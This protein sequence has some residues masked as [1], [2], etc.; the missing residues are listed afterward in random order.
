MLGRPFAEFI[1]GD[2]LP[3]AMRDFESLLGGSLARN[4][5]RVH[6]GDGSVR[7]IRVS[8]TPR[9]V[10]D[11]FSGFYTI[12]DDITDER[13]LKEVQAETDYRIQR[14]FDAIP[15][16]VFYK[17]RD[18]VYQACN[19]T[20]AR[21]ILGLEAEQVVG[22]SL[23]DL[24]EHVP[25]DLHQ[26]YAKADRELLNQPGWQQYETEVQC[27]D[28]V[29][30]QFSLSKA[31]VQ[32]S[33]GRIV[34]IVGAMLD[35]SEHQRLTDQLKASQKNLADIIQRSLDGIL[36][37]NG[38]SRILFGNSAAAEMLG[39]DINHLERHRFR[40]EFEPDSIHDYELADVG[41]RE[42]RVEVV[43]LRT[44]W[45]DQSA[46]LVQIRDVGARRKAEQE[47]VRSAKVESLEL[48]AGGVAHDFNNILTAVI[49]NLSFVRLEQTLNERASAALN[50]AEL[51]AARAQSL[52]Q[53]LLSFAKGGPPTKKVGSLSEVI[54]DTIQFIL[55]GS[56][57][58]C[59]FIIPDDLWS[60]NMDEGQISQVIENLAINASQSMSE[61]GN[62][63]IHVENLVLDE[64][65]VQNLPNLQPGKHVR[66][67]LTDEG[68]GIPADVLVRIFDPYFTTKE[69]GNGL[70]L[71]VCRDVIRKH[72][73]Y[74]N[75]RSTAGKGT[76]F[77]IYLPALGLTA[78]DASQEKKVIKRGSGRV[79]VM[80][81]EESIRMVLKR[82]LQKLGYEADMCPDGE[83]AVR[84]Y[85]EA[86]ESNHPYGA[87]LLDM[88]IVGGMGGEATFEQL[89]EMDPSVK[90]IVS[91]GYVDNEMLTQYIGKGFTGAAPKPYSAQ[92]L[93]QILY[94][95]I[96]KRN[97][98]T[99]TVKQ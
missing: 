80:D 63:F 23:D 61:G 96:S 99:S 42:G 19:S 33:S 75:V 86:M 45:N 7:W 26:R 14:I 25:A 90:A 93:S 27:A 10:N 4:E 62:L 79:L 35:L 12:L 2:D 1:Y 31:T 67:T 91:S 78:T 39:V 65:D 97:E 28:G 8:S 87:V 60:V 74:I 40:V 51:A 56:R 55:S 20:F 38:D 50:D 34:G 82:M 71:A 11:V 85:R 95:A 49:G 83:A 24:S 76:I 21:W 64:R 77:T 17:D 9:I 58:K 47:A 89:K 59:H 6:A 16:P 22:K 72:D 81:D 30:R 3:N 29:R 41:F 84:L 57:S 70:G 44:T 88:T 13:R 15:V 68:C 54:R 36:V 32:S 66:I 37:L 46:M 69:N 18:G 98:R 5:Y 73:G 48:V 43:T 92:K 94:D 52:T 53:Q